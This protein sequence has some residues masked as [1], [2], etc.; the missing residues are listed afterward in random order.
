MVH[1]IHL[2]LVSRQATPNI[3]PALDPDFRPREVA[4]LVSPDM[5]RQADAL[6]EVLS[7]YGLKV[8]RWPIENAWDIEHVRDRVLDFLAGR[9]GE[10]VALNATGGTKPMS[11]AAYEA[12]RALERPIFYVHPEKDRVV[13][14]Y[15][16]GESHD[17]GDRV[18]L[19]AFLQAHGARLEKQ[20]GNQGVSPARRELT[21][22]LVNDVKCLAPALTTLNWAAAQAQKG[23]VSPPLNPAQ[24]RNP[25]LLDL[26]GRFEEEGLLAWEGDGLRFPDEEA[27]A[28][29]NGGWFEDHVYGVIFGL[30]ARMQSKGRSIQDFGRHLQVSRRVGRELVRNELDVAFLADNRLYIIECKTQRFDNSA[31][32]PGSRGAAALYK[33]DALKDLL[34]GLQG[35]A[36]LV[37]YQVLPP[38]DRQRARD[39]NIQVCSGAETSGLG[40]KIEAWVQ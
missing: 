11:I 1:E 4:L 29:V 22:R 9:E 24:R 12:F 7:A 3:T 2:A 30:R 18:K 37:T 20:G 28:Y 16:H 31:P 39:L 38:V 23:L 6:T 26:I 17:L 33:L 32:G 27:R 8:S 21:N 36:M 14:L 34:G 15:P 10:A 5:I 13:W 25:L 19:P 40:K 35:R